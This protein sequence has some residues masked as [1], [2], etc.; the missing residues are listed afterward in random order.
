MSI[1]NQVARHLGNEVKNDIKKELA[2]EVVQETANHITHHDHHG[3]F[4]KIETLLAT[5]GVH[6]M[7]VGNITVKL[8]KGE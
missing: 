7:T 3:L 4:G 6:E 1:I 5:L 2:N 8:N